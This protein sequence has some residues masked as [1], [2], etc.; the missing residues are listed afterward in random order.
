MIEGRAC[1]AQA[2]LGVFAWTEKEKPEKLACRAA[3]AETAAKAK[4]LARVRPKRATL[5]APYG[6]KVKLNFKRRRPPARPSCWRASTPWPPSEL[7]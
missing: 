3:Q 4:L 2:T 5:Q 1:A 7:Q 6:P